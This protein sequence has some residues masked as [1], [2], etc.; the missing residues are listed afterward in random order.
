M[1]IQIINNTIRLD[2]R[3]VLMAWYI[4]FLILYTL[5]TSGK[6]SVIYTIVDYTISGNMPLMH[7]CNYRPDHTGYS[8]YFIFY[9]FIVFCMFQ[10]LKSN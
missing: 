1:D 6:T 9:F 3:T 2:S 4:L 8:F 7:V 5:T 10:L